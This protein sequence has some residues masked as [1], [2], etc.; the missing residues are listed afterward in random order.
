MTNS[1]KKFLLTKTVN[2]IKDLNKNN[3]IGANMP[4]KISSDERTSVFQKFFKKDIKMAGQFWYSK[5][6]RKDHDKFGAPRFFAMID[7]KLVEYTEMI[8]FSDL[9]TDPE[10]RCFYQDAKYL[11]KG[12]FDH[13][14]K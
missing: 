6:Q 13:R 4:G 1:S 9:L 10:D 8:D 3:S 2:L 5:Q 14:K 12:F 7:G 11:G